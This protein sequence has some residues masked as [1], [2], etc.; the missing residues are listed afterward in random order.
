MGR[1]TIAT[2]LAVLAGVGAISHSVAAH[3][4]VATALSPLLATF[5]SATGEPPAQI[6]R[7]VLPIPAPPFRGHLA[8]TVEDSI[9]DAYRPV[10]APPGAPNVLVVLTDDVGFGA[11]STFGGLIS[12]PHLD[13]LARTGLRYNNFHDPAICSATRAALLTGR[14]HHAVGAGSVVEVAAP[15]PG[16]DSVIPLSAATIARVLRE[17]GYNTAMFGKH[18]N[19]ARQNSSAAGPYDTWPTGLGFEYFYGFIGGDDDQYRPTLYRDTARVPTPTKPGYILDADLADDAIRWIHGQKGAAP[20]KPFFVYFSPGTTHAPHQAPREWIDRF[21]GKFDQGWDAIREQIHAR[22]EKLGIIPPSTRMAPRLAG[23]PAWSSLT[24]N[25]KKLDARMMEVY[26]GCLAFQ[27]EQIGRII[28]ELKRMGELDNTLVLY[29]EGDNGPSGEGT[30]TGTTNEMGHLGNRMPEDMPYLMSV[31][32]KLGG[33]EEYNNYPA[34]WA[35]AMSTPFPW[36]KQIASHLGGT[37]NGLVARWPNHIADAGQIRTQFHDI[38]DIY[39]TILAAANIPVPTSVDGTKQTPIDGTKMNYTFQR[40]YN[41]PSQRHTQYFEMLGN[42]AIYNDGWWANTTPK[43]PPWSEINPVGN[44]ETSYHWELY[45]LT[46]DFAQ[47]NDVAAKNPEK[48]RQLQALWKKEAERNFVF[49]L[50]DQVGA[51]RYNIA[52]RRATPQ[53]SHWVYW[54]PLGIPEGAAPSL[55]SRSFSIIADVE[56]PSEAQGV[57]LATGGRFGGWSF[58]LKDGNVVAF[59]AFSQRPEH[60]HKVVAAAP[61]PGSAVI[62]FDFDYAGGDPGNGGTMRISINGTQKAIGN[63]AHVDIVPQ[64][65]EEFDIGYDSGTK[66][67]PEYTDDFPFSGTIK[68]VVLDLR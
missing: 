53:R 11:A 68:R 18:H 40:G 43:R 66:V 12:T 15:Y 54:G 30:L 51:G 52:M 6:D 49:P 31:I 28:D 35:W 55:R 19:V 36:M 67:S 33:P 7:T 39:P 45:N 1:R 37:T 22:Q 38:V 4:V 46:N 20:D 32:D 41:G 63:I 65:T 5:S 42:R 10:Q 64:N 56:I 23:I 26:A 58:Y 21:K 3:R 24:T 2:R 17:N 14:N 47:A 61:G 48:L 27:D 25:Q 50:Q 13:E 9:G 29:V 34:G 60:H 57:L 16:Y 62:R 8:A 44:A 59:D